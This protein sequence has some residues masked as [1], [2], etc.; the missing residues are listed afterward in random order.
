MKGVG[1]T[2]TQIKKPS[3]KRFGESEQKPP[4]RRKKNDN[5]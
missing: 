2:L 3:G 4:L 1:K 5:Q